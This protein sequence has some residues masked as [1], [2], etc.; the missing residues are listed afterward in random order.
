MDKFGFLF[1]APGNPALDENLLR[2]VDEGVPALLLGVDVRGGDRDNV[3]GP[4]HVGQWSY[5]V[6]YTRNNL[7]I[8][9]KYS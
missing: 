6:G 8:Y 4:Q 3:V 9:A 5:S 1:F 7:K 2:R